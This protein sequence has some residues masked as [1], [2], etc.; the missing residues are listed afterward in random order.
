MVSDWL[1]VG[2]IAG[3]YGVMGWVKV[4]SHTQPRAGIL[5]YNPLYLSNDGDW[6]PLEMQAGRLQGKGVILKL[7]GYADRSACAPLVGRHIAIRRE[8]LPPLP[9][10]E[11]Y[12][13]DLQGLQVVTQHGVAL[14]TVERLFETGANDV[15]VVD[16]ERERLIPF[17]RDEVILKV[18][19][20]QGV[21]QVDWDPTF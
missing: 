13:A 3:L 18:D 1:L 16:G 9:P 5:N 6:Q 12:W 15:L 17:I 7:S 21:I 20:A 19:L 10:D 14:G 2:Q 4:I 11:Y 8:Q